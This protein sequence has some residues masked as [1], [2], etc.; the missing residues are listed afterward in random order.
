M[1]PYKY[2][3]KILKGQEGLTLIMGNPDR[4]EMFTYSDSKGNIVTKPNIKAGFVSGT[5]PVGETYVSGVIA[6]PIGKYIINKFSSI[7]KSMLPTNYTDRLIIALGSKYKGPRSN[8]LINQ[9]NQALADYL[10]KNGVDISKFSNSDLTN[11]S[12]MRRKVITNTFPSGRNATVSTS[13]SSTGNYND[14]RLRNKDK[15]IGYLGTYSKNKKS[16]V[17]EIENYFSG[18][19]KHVSEDLYNAAI[20]VAKFQNT[21]GLISGEYL[22]SPEQTYKIWDLYRKKRLIGNNG[23][24]NFN[25]GEY[26]IKAGNKY[27]INNG[28]IYELV[29]PSKETPT[30]SL[31]IF[32]PSMV[33]KNGIFTTN[34]SDP[35]IYKLL[36]IG[37]IYDRR[38]N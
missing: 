20:K 30:K 5:D 38:N 3:S 25:N 8:D 37:L 2:R 17:S 11:L 32:H 35:N 12:N 21:P 33:T 23:I 29:S 26:V 6:G 16:Y 22:N 4:D 7:V 24:H 28:N 27:T 31:N 13:K 10:S 34:W 9:E 36:P 14:I 18:K 19:E 15:E 1:K